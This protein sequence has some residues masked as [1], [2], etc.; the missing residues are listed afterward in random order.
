MQKSDDLN[1]VRLNTIEQLKGF[2]G[3][4]DPKALLLQEKLCSKFRLLKHQAELPHYFVIESLG[5]FRIGVSYKCQL[6][7]KLLKRG[8]GPDYFP[9]HFCK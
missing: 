4:D 5:G 8:R 2:V 3:H 7:A 9:R 1:R 6:L